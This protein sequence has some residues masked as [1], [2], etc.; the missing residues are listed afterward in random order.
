V[1]IQIDEKKKRLSDELIKPPMR[2]LFNKLGLVAHS[3]NP[4]TW[5]AH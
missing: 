4:G 2:K 1:I 5:E 3:Y